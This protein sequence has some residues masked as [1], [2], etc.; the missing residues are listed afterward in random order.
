M[1]NKIRKE[2]FLTILKKIRQPGLDKSSY[3]KG[4][5]AVLDQINHFINVV[6]NKEKDE[7]LVKQLLK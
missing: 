1:M 5:L 3:E 7:T 4:Y 2:I 6:E